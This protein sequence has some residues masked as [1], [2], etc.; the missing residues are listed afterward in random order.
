MTDL[1]LIKKLTLTYFGFQVV[2]ISIL[3]IGL[4]NETILLYCHNDNNNQNTISRFIIQFVNSNIFT[5]PIL[6]DQN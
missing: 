4:I 2:S 3:S 5:A 1:D 6:I